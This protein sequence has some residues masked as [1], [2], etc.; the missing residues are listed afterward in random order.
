[1]SIRDGVRGRV[2]MIRSVDPD[3][4]RVTVEYRNGD[5][6]WFTQ[7]PPLEFEVGSVWLIGD[8]TMVPADD[9]LWPDRSTFAVVAAVL[10]H[11]LVIEHHGRLRSLR[12]NAPATHTVGSTIEL[13]NLD[14]VLRVVSDRPLRAYG[15][16][17]PDENAIAD[18]RRPPTTGGP[19]FESF[20]GYSKVVARARELVEAP[21]RWRAELA[22]IGARPVKG[23][24]F[25]GPPGTGKT[26]LASLIANES[27]ARFYDV[28]GPVIVSK[29]VGDSEKALRCLFQEARS[30]EGSAIIFFD[31]IDSI[32]GRRDGESHEFSRRVVATLLTE[33][34]SF[35]RHTNVVVIGATNRIADIDPALR[36]P[37]RF[38]WIVEF[39][40]P[41]RDDR[42]AI[43]RVSAA[44]L[45]TKGSLPH[46]AVA[47]QTEGWSPAD[48]T[49]ILTEAALLAVQDHGR[50]V[51][52][53][54]D[55]LGGFARLVERRNVSMA[56]DEQ[57]A[58]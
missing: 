37:G 24:L 52:L 53:A 17:D 22:A 55:Y 15:L 41:D 44:A 45:A 13:D 2:A 21:L 33:M 25:A 49:A 40:M 14:R 48:L 27:N 7:S 6:G 43:L 36:R 28:S 56:I 20:G 42:E 51:I 3:R 18:F 19:G 34:D 23:V 10:D 26:K 57:A 58:G 9:D 4:N 47:A 39:P 8:G 1:M 35:T 54:E 32:A 46:A 31:E 5:T 50:S 38:D 11:S 29:W 30:E 16:S 12:L